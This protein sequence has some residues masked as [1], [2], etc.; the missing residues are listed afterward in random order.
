[1]RAALA[2]AILLAAGAAAAQTNPAIISNQPVP[3]VGLSTRPAGGAPPFFPGVTPAPNAPPVVNAGPTTP[4]PQPAPEQ[5][6]PTTPFQQSGANF[7][8]PLAPFTMP[9]ATAPFSAPLTPGTTPAAFAPQTAVSS[10]PASATTPQ[11]VGGPTTGTGTTGTGTT[12]TATTSPPAGAR[13]VPM[14]ELRRPLPP[15][16]STPEE[17]TSALEALERDRAGARKAVRLEFERRRSAMAQADDWKNATQAQRARRLRDLRTDF[18]QRERLL[19]ADYGAER[20]RL[21][22]RL[23]RLKK[24]AS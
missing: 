15:P 10:G 16:P 24:E 22:Q 23:R 19:D 9:T 20:A 6:L 17:V 4:A 5:P 2:S 3:G 14:H 18:R 21:E 7:T 12:G 13:S 1:M 8:T 11:R